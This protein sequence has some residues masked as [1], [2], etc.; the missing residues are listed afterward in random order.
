MT[1]TWHKDV[2]GFNNLKS[3]FK[4]SIQAINQIDD[5]FE[6]NA[7]VKRTELKLHNIECLLNQLKNTLKDISHSDPTEYSTFNREFRIFKQEWIEMK[8]Q[9]SRMNEKYSASEIECNDSRS[10]RKLLLDMNDSFANVTKQTNDSLLL[11]CESEEIGTRTSHTLNIQGMQLD[12][13]DIQVREMNHSSDR[14]KKIMRS[15]TKNM[16]SNRIMQTCIVLLEIA[17]II[18]LL[19]W[20]LLK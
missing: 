20:K 9:L 5:D 6:R 2:K 7:T 11:I 4:R 13:I 1:S 16:F 15:L 19:W 8:K 17:I 3:S 18:F 10:E 12:R 14:S